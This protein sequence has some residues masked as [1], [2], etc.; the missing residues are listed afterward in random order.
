[1]SHSIVTYGAKK[2]VT[3]ETGCK[4]ELPF[5]SNVTTVGKKQN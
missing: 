2:N 3:Y 4:Q 5:H 1:M